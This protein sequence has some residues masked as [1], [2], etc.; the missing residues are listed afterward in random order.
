[1]S[2]QEQ[3]FAAGLIGLISSSAYASES[4][5]TQAFFD[6]GEEYSYLVQTSLATRHF[7]PRPEHNN[8]QQFKG[9]ERFGENYFSRYLKP[10]LDWL[11]DATP[12]L[13]AA[14]F[15]NSYD[16]PSVYAYTGFRRPLLYNHQTQIYAKVTVGLIHGYRG[17]YRD[18][19]PLNQLGTAPV[20][21]PSL[22]L[23]HKRTNMEMI[24]F[25]DSGVM[26]NVGYS[27]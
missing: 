7:N 17:L 14:Y 1:M 8:S 11:Q 2:V 26:L 12:I 22:G 19:I 5:R 13:G 25:G 23:Q 20:A 4:T 3:L 9:I 16:Q 10:R 21:I 24:F 18:R 27:F 6:V 15:R